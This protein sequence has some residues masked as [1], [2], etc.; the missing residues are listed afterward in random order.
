MDC[1]IAGVKTEA[2]SPGFPEVIKQRN[3]DMKA[4]AVEPAESPVITQTTMGGSSAGHSQNSDIGAGLFEK[5]EHRL[6]MMW[7]K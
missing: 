5:L 6:L 3:P 2:Q 1:L 4:I 7:S